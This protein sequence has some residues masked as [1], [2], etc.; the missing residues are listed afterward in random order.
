MEA[1]VPRELRMER[2]PPD[3]A[4]TD[5]NNLS[6]VPGEGRGL[7]ADRVDTRGPDEHSGERASLE[8]LDPHRSLERLP[9]GA[10]V[11]ATDLNIEDTQG[12]GVESGETWDELA[13]E[14]D[15]PGACSEDR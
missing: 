6:A 5:P 8:P 7:G 11:V 15:E 4:R 3:R 12:G 1:R 13:R 9:L 14:Q 2:E 10:V